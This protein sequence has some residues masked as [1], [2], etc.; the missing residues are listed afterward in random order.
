MSLSH[1][2]RRSGNSKDSHRKGTTIMDYYKVPLGFG[3]ALSMNPRA[4][5][6]YSAMSPEEKRDILSKA[7]SAH[8]Q[9]EMQTLVASLAGYTTQ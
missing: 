7:H 2:F 8:S 6:A 9:K 4:L 3:M 5:N 1:A